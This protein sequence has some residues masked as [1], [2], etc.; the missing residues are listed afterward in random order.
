MR[1][2]KR[3]EE[4]SESESDGDEEEQDSTPKPKK[5]K[6]SGIAGL[7][8]GFIPVINEKWAS[9]KQQW[10]QGKLAFQ[11]FSMIE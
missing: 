7:L 11:E 8:C 4:E 5:L 2:P 3:K 9:E 10:L 6:I 1:D